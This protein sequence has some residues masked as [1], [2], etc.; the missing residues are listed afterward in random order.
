[1]LWFAIIFL[2][3]SNYS[4]I[5]QMMKFM[6]RALQGLTRLDCLKIL[7]NQRRIIMAFFKARV[8]LEDA[9]KLEYF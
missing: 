5:W 8:R 7:R 1:M 2:Q 3:V 4:R 9:L 6:P